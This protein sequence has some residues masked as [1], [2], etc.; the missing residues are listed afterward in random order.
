MSE[1]SAAYRKVLE[2]DFAQLQRF[3]ES[4]ERFIGR[5][6]DDLESAVAHVASLDRGNP[7]VQAYANALFRE[8]REDLRNTY[9]QALRFAVFVMVACRIEHHLRLLCNGEVKKPRGTS[10]LRA[11]HSHIC[12]RSKIAFAAIPCLHVVEF[13]GVIRN[14]LVHHDMQY[15]PA[16]SRSAT[17]YERTLNELGTIGVTA[18]ERRQI[19]LLSAT[20]KH[21]I[22][23]AVSYLSALAECRF[24]E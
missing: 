17:A 9:P 20:V 21:Y 1:A 19:G 6:L 10:Y 13:Y 14:R 18:D 24:A 2:D 8:E 11:V 16:G 5:D 23:T 22:A 3:S 4:V 15:F 12:S 7:K